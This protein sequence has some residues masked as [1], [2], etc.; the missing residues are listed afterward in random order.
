MVDVFGAVAARIT[1][2]ATSGRTLVAIDGVDGSGKTTFTAELVRRLHTRP[3]IVLHADDFLNPSAVRHARGRRSPHGFWLDS[4]NYPALC[5]DAL[6]PLRPGGDGWY[7]TASY[8][9]DSDTVVRPSPRWAPRN[10]IVV[11][12]GMFLHRDE[13]AD[14][15]DTSVFLDVPFDV[16]VARMA[17]RDGTHPDPAHETV[18]RYVDGQRLYFARSQ[19]WSRAGIVIDNTRYDQPNIVAP[20]HAHAAR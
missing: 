3:V 11:V 15:W 12:E 10:A 2:G 19:P 14:I 1:E 6:D 16:T 5:R 9:P 13:L 18:R 17:E 7:R 20:E 4:Y 8:D